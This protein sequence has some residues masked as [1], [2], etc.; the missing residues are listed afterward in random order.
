[1]RRRAMALVCLLGT[2]LLLAAAACAPATGPKPT[3]TTTNTP[4][5]AV[6]NTSATAGAAPLSVFFDA[7]SSTDADGTVAS[8]AWDFDD[9]N[10]ATTDAL[11]HTF[12]ALGTYTVTLTV[13]DDDGATDTET[14]TIVVTNANLSPTAVAGA[15]PTSGTEPLVVSFD[16]SSSFDPD[17]TIVSHA[18]DF[19]DGNTSTAAN[20]SHTYPTPGIY[21]AQLTVTD[22][23][24]AT[25]TDTKQITVNPNQ[26]PTAVA[27]AVPTS[28]RFPLDVAFDSSSSTDNDGTIVSQA[29][30]FGDGNTSTAVSPSHTYP[31]PGTY[32]AELTVTDNLGATGTDTVAITVNPNQAPTAVATATPDTGQAPLSVSFSSALSTDNDGS[33]VSWFWDFGGGNQS[34]AANPNYTFATDGTYNVNLTVTDNDGATNTTTVQVVVDP[35]PNLLPT[36]VA[37]AVPSTVRQGLPVAFSSAGSIDPDGTIVGYAWDFGDGGTSTSANP[38]HT[39][40]LANTYTVQL[41]VT[42][43]AG[44]TGTTTVQVVVEA[45]QNP[46]AVASGS[47]LTGEEPLSVTFDGS[48]VDT[49]GTIVGYAWNFGDGG[50]STAEDPSHT[51][52]TPGTYTATL[53]V[54]D[55]FGGTGTD[56]AQVTVIV[57]PPPTAGANAVP[58]SGPEDLIVA[59]DGSASADNGTIVS[60]AWD[61]D[62]GGSSTSVNPS[63]TYTAPG[64]YGATLTV[65]DNG[66][67]TDTAT[68]T[69]TVTPDADQDGVSPPSDCDDN[70]ANI[71]PGASDPIGDGIDQ[72]CDTADGDAAT[73]AF[74]SNSGTDTGTCGTLVNQC[75]TIA[76]G[77]ARA[78]ATSKTSVHV[79]SGTYGSFSAASGIT[80]RG[81]FASSFLATSGTTT[82]SGAPGV[83]ASGVTGAT[84][85]NMTINGTAGTGVLVQSA[86]DVDLTE[87]VVSSGSPSGAGS[88]AYGVRVIGGST[89]DV[90]D[91]TV[92][93]ANGVAGTAGTAGSAGS[94]GCTGNNGGNH[95]DSDNL[96]GASCGGSGIGASG[97]GGRGGK[98]GFT[99]CGATDE[100]NGS[101]GGGGNGGAGGAK[102]TCHYAGADGAGGGGGGGT[103]S[104]VANIP[105]ASGGAG[106]GG[107][108]DAGLAGS[109]WAGR[110]GTAGSAGGLGR[111]GGGGGGGGATGAYTWGGGGG[112]GGGGGTAGTGGN[113]GTAGGGSFGVYSHNS[114]LS[115]T[116]STVT[117][118]SGGAGGAGG[119]GGAGGKGGNGGNGGTANGALQAA[120][121]GGGGGAGGAGGSGGGGGG[122]G[123]PSIAIANFG[124]SLTHSSNT[125]SRAA[126]AASAGTAGAGGAGGAVGSAGAQ[127]SSNRGSQPG[128]TGVAGATGAAATAG[129]AGMLCTVYNGGCTP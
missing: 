32:T 123:G 13:T 93:A 43:N 12:T 100:T 17:G 47:P 63:H 66:G 101:A 57:N 111:G 114:T 25:G 126:S 88:S 58:Q 105:G 67:K 99:D 98:G 36:A 34:T 15:T 5:T 116:G 86:A 124:G 94:T 92:T 19:G 60:Y 41:T 117:S 30:D 64:T 28:G 59:F 44:G 54:T 91:S 112:A 56:S 77:V 11:I 95:N 69:I 31:T 46:T 74:V 8:Y 128:V 103:S 51:Y 3:T 61:F 121:G 16:S 49:D 84:V 6:I 96:G 104:P 85:R 18:W 115:V 109:T 39:F 22:D 78:V 14:V 40:A 72:N 129:G 79:A 68:V 120:G 27:G 80:V 37:A 33:I 108:N 90:A 2:F 125:T 65:T 45:N 10:T 62:D 119:S 83:T 1:M 102:G 55:D 70:D 21:T 35:V 4:P 107:A 71:K 9:G 76:Q 20:P 97:A 87:V 81:S 48:G 50:T 122:A 7:T 106:S 23:D 52:A 24:G 42:D 29:W 89:L 82:V 53:V 118:G 113:G 75:A 110:S 127:G 26:A 38:S 73:I